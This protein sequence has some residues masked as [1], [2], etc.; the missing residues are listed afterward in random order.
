MEGT[1]QATAELSLTIN[2][3]YDDFREFYQS[4]KA[5]IYDA[6]VN[7]FRILSETDAVEVS[8]LVNATVENVNWDTTFRLNRGRIDLL[9]GTILPYYVQEEAY[10]K[11]MNINNILEQLNNKQ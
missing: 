9:T 7:G 8:L 4:S 6:I 5:T 3:P 1:T 11:C 2:Q 10:E